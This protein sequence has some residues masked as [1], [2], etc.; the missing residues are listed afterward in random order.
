MIRHFSNL[1]PFFFCE[2]NLIV[3]F[4]FLIK[5]CN[6]LFIIIVFRL[7]SDKLSPV[8]SSVFPKGSVT[9]VTPR[10]EVSIN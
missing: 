2:F 7:C 6:I 8:P 1:S 5:Y 4:P 10:L 9:D 3:L